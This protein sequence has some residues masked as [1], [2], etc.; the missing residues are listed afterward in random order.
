[1]SAVL[2]RD[3]GA[4]RR[5]SVFFGHQKFGEKNQR[6]PLFNDSVT[7]KNGGEFLEGVFASCFLFLFPDIMDALTHHTPSSCAQVEL[8]K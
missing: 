8:C 7:Q 5:R 6:E 1:M 4:E 3:S 2:A